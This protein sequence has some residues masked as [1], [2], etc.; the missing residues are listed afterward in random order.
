MSAAFV[1]FSTAVVCLDCNA[2]SAAPQGKC[3]RCSSTAVMTLA[4][5][6][7]QIAPP[8]AKVICGAQSVSVT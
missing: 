7:G 8:A 5:K 3:V 1:E 4:D 6:L 2:V